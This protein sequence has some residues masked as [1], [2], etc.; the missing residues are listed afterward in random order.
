MIKITEQFFVDIHN[1]SLQSSLLTIITD[2]IKLKEQI[3]FF[4]FTESVT[5]FN[6][7]KEEYNN[8]L[9]EALSLITKLRDKVTEL[10]E[11]AER[12]FID[13]PNKID[14]EKIKIIDRKYQG[15]EDFVF[16]ALKALNELEEIYKKLSP[17]EITT[18]LTTERN[19]CITRF[20]TMLHNLWAR[21]NNIA[22][23]TTYYP[24]N[25]EGVNVD[26]A[27]FAIPHLE[28]LLQKALSHYHRWAEN[29]VKTR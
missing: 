16:L 21:L 25:F 6:S 4:K 5:K 22:T 20:N 17:N 14:E 11:K 7:K 18:E 19:K 27:Y 28:T 9:K 26:A 10:I 1:I 15:I 8:F 29:S 12:T 13:S 24:K 2:C 23:G 3:L